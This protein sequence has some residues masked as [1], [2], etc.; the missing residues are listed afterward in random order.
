MHTV[1]GPDHYVPLLAIGVAGG[2]KWRKLLLFTLACGLGHVLSSVLLGG[3][4]A[5]L[6]RAFS[7]VAAIQDVAGDVAGWGLVAVG[8]AYA[9]WGLVFGRKSHGHAHLHVHT[10]GTVHAHG[11]DHQS[12]SPAAKP[13]SS[14]ARAHARNEGHHALA[15]AAPW[16]LFLLFAFGPCEPLVAFTFAAGLRQDWVGLAGISAAFSVVTLATMAAIVMS[17]HAGLVRLDTAGLQRY[18]HF[19]AG[20]VIA[21]S[22]LS[23]TVLGL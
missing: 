23:I 1:L 10:D 4:G 21:L 8:G 2:W 20:L 13:G 9:A 18:V 5:A 3:V 14:P 12:A 15:A 17:A 7:A 22:G 16:A 11:H 6:G 19:L